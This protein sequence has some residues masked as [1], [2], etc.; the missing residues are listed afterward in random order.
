M[1]NGNDHGGKVFREAWIA[2]VTT[3]YPG[4]P[5][6]G[7]ITPW[8]N[9]PDWERASAAAV[10]RQVVD[11]LTVTD[12]AATRLS[13]E[14]KGQFVAICW[15]GQIYARIPDPKPGYVAPWDQLPEW[16]QKTDIGVFEAIE[17]DVAAGKVAA[18]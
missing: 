6:D 14:Q 11:F 12:G 18:E 5:K 4:T 2:G 8:E 15:I 3:H 9:T 7:Y 13:P 17:R 10:Y 16:Q 1:S